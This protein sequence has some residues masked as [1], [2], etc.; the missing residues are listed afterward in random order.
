MSDGPDRHLFSLILSTQFMN[1]LLTRLSSSSSSSSLRLPQPVLRN[2][3]PHQFHCRY[4]SSLRSDCLLR[5]RRRQQQPPLHQP[6]EHAPRISHLYP[7][8]RSH[9]SL[10]TA[11]SYTRSLTMAADKAVDS[12]SEQ[13]AQLPPLDKYPNCY[14]EINPVDIYR[15]HASNHDY[16]A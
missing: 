6:I 7:V 13:L 8:P 4:F 10:S 5:R 12:L 9:P 1:P 2:I 14:P 15:A 3:S 11:F 16:I